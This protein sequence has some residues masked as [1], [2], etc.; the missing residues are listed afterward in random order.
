[1][2]AYPADHG[3]FFLKRLGEERYN[4]LVIRAHRPV[5]VDEK[6]IAKYWQE[7]LEKIQEELNDQG[8]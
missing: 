6:F 4:D 2:A 3:Q 8:Y 7:K 5:K 1:M